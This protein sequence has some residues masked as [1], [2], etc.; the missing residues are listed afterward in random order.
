MST[1]AT[2][3]PLPTDFVAKRKQYTSI[4]AF[5]TDLG[6]EL[7]LYRQE[8]REHTGNLRSD[9]SVLAHYKETLSDLCFPLP[10]PYL[11]AFENNLTQYMANVSSLRKTILADVYSTAVDLSAHA[12]NC[13]DPFWTESRTDPVGFYDLQCLE[14]RAVL[15]S[16]TSKTVRRLFKERLETTY[17][18]NRDELFH[19]GER[20]YTSLI[21]A[22]RTYSRRGGYLP[23][24]S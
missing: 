19:E 20:L 12:E 5:V 11:A 21:D 1:V 18:D 9:M 10:R 7:A 6:K 3:I 8:H 23:T 15:R 24:N 16:G 4:D 14:R 17:H 2:S 22:L 13:D